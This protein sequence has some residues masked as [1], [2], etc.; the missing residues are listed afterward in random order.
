[1][2]WAHRSPPPS[3][4]AALPVSLSSSKCGLAPNSAL[5]PEPHDP[6]RPPSPEKG[7]VGWWEQGGRGWVAGSPPHL[8]PSSGCS[9]TPLCFLP[10]LCPGCKTDVASCSQGAFLFLGLC[11]ICLVMNLEVISHRRGVFTL[12]SKIQLIRDLP[13][14]SSAWIHRPSGKA[15]EC[16]DSMLKYSNRS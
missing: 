1:M 16:I 6:Q 9:P 8:R 5:A 11:N 12:F 14:F 15:K 7:A 2:Y 4:Q 13:C 3:A 10:A